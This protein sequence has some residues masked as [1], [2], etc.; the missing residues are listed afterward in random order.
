MIVH[1]VEEVAVLDEPAAVPDAVRAADVNG[2]GDRRRSVG[3][4]R[5]DGAVDVVVADE[6]ER[7]PMILCGI[8]RFGAGEIEA[9]DAAVFVGDREL[10]H[11]VAS[12]PRRC[13]GS[14]TR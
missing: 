6:L 9:D 11:L 12:A 2:L 1:V 7:V 3:L 8:V 10:R 5:V 13:S 14:R 4:A